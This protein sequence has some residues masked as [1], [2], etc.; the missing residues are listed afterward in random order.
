MI[1][2]PAASTQTPAAAVSLPVGH[3]DLASTFCEIAG[4]DTP[5]WV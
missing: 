4:I 5:P 1:W 3:L 2:R